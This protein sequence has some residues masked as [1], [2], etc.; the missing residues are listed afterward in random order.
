MFLEMQI[1]VRLDVAKVYAGEMLLRY[2]Q[3]PPT[4]AKATACAQQQ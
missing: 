1:L 2:L 4:L 3:G